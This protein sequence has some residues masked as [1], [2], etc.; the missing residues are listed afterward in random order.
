MLFFNKLNEKQQVNSSTHLQHLDKEQD[1]HHAKITILVNHYVSLMV[2]FYQ[3]YVDILADLR[4]RAGE[5][6]FLTV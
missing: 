6:L 3:S 4:A 5:I 2:L 1:S